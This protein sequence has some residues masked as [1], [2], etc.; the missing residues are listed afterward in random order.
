MACLSTLLCINA[1]I[2]TS[3]AAVSSLAAAKSISGAGLED[4]YRLGA[5]FVVLSAVG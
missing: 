5:G 3:L 2:S 1:I 4:A